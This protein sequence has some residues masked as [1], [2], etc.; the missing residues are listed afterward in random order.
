[1]TKHLVAYVFISYTVSILTRKTRQ[2]EL[3]DSQK[4]NQLSLNQNLNLFFVNIPSI[5]YLLH[6]PQ[7]ILTESFNL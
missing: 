4:F 7:Y 1:M 6:Y 3:E 2:R 5:F